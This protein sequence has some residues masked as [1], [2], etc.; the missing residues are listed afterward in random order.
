MIASK[1]LLFGSESRRVLASNSNYCHDSSRKIVMDK[2]GPLLQVRSHSNKFIGEGLFALRDIPT[3][4]RFIYYGKLMSPSCLP[5]SKS[6]MTIQI[7]YL[8]FLTNKQRKVIGLDKKNGVE[9]LDRVVIDGR[10]RPQSR[11]VQSEFLFG[12]LKPLFE[13]FKQV[14]LLEMFRQNLYV[15]DDVKSYPVPYMHKVNHYVDFSEENKFLGTENVKIQIDAVCKV[16]EPISEGDELLVD[17]GPEAEFI[18]TRSLCY[19]L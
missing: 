10:Y 18:C 5:K 1:K 2:D 16:I 15:F 12:L 19:S 13:K 17:Y 9:C 7:D 14:P 6:K 8:S 4:R 3:S 11:D